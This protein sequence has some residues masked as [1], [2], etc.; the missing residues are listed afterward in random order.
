MYF[1]T[2]IGKLFSSVTHVFRE[3]GGAREGEIKKNDTTMYFVSYERTAD[4]AHYWQNLLYYI[5]V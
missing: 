1:G 4:N 3:P 5:E 2:R